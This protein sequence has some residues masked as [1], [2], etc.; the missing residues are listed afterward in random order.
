MFN[1]LKFKELRKRKKISVEDFAKLIGS[2]SATLYHYQ[3]GRTQ[4][5]VE[6]IEKMVEVLGTSY[7][8]LTKISENTNP[9]KDALV[10]ELK[11]KNEF[12]EKEINYFKQM[13]AF[14]TD[15]KVKDEFVKLRGNLSTASV[16]MFPAFKIA[17]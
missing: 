7:E 14:L 11:S 17:K 3:T 13:I 5:S 9:Y 15:G 10:S 16:P 12:L 6:V 8:E 1:H 2:T 4:P